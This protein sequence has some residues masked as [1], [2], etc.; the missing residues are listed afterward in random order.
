[1]E[2]ILTFLELLQNNNNREWFHQHKNEYEKAR[3]EFIKIVE[4]LISR[5]A[6]FDSGIEMLNPKDTIFR[7]YRD[8]RFSPNKL[9][10]KTN[11]GAYIARGG[12][13][14]IFAGYYLHIEPGNSFAG[15]G[16]YRPDNKILL[17]IRRALENNPDKFL[18]IVNNP[19]FSSL[20]KLDTSDKLKKVPRGFSSKSPVLE[21]LKLKSFVCGYPLKNE[22]LL[23]GSYFDLVL[24][25]YKNMYPLIAFLND[26]IL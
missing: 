21:Y 19:E 22:Q 10:Y 3:S 13:Q 12:R 14:S 6:C 18:Q 20:L 17:K 25:I 2:Q 1:M 16:L 7:I 23:N 26:A 5:I 11:M 15:G 24:R 8:I 4:Q 9:P